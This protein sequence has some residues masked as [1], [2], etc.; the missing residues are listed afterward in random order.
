MLF[1]SLLLA[2]PSA[3]S[4]TSEETQKQTCEVGYE[5]KWKDGKCEFSKENRFDKYEYEDD[6]KD[7]GVYEDYAERNN[8]KE[9]YFKELNNDN[10]NRD[11]VDYYCD[12][13][14]EYVENKKKCDKLYDGVEKQEEEN[15]KEMKEYL[16]EQEQFE[17]KLPSTITT[18]REVNED[19]EE[20]EPAEI[21]EEEESEDEDESEEQEVE[22]EN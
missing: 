14:E 19:F 9:K 11:I 5:A 1:A 17:H 6:L 3:F 12:A 8:L 22:V 15:K 10:V 20:E 21:V 16:E 13:S 18:D 7:S 4:P 2:L